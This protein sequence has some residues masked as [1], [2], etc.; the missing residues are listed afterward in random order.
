[1]A[2]KIDTSEITVVVQGAFVPETKECL[3]SIRHYLPNSKIV[4]ST[5]KGSDVSFCDAD[6]IVF[7]IDP[8]AFVCQINGKKRTNNI[9]RQILSTKNGLM[10]AKTKYAL[11][12]RTDFKLCGTE[13]LNY[14]C[15]FPAYPQDATWKIFKH[16][17]INF[18][19]LPEDCK[20]IPFF[21]T[22]FAFFGL[23]EDLMFLF[24]IPLKSEEWGMWFKTQT[25]A[26]PELYHYWQ[27]DLARFG[28][29]EYII[30]SA[31]SKIKKDIFSIVP[32]WSYSTREHFEKGHLFVLSNFITLDY[33]QFPLKSIA[34][35]YLSPL[36]SRKTFSAYLLKYK[37]FCNP[38]YKLPFKYILERYL[39][40]NQKSLKKI[41]K[42]FLYI[43][44]PFKATILWIIAVLGIVILSLRILTKLVFNLLI[45]LLKRE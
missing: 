24:D 29:E 10:R 9:N 38:K 6:E 22:D 11:K 26:N 5:W 20:Q 43:I 7:N 34:K 23:T 35:D 41:Q 19:D 4:L 37:K 31:L 39:H 44:A 12:M 13:F 25:P 33:R 36:N 18:C 40:K 32:D 15:A 45:L 21:V 8:G 1:M 28:P 17:V 14:F 16:K 27:G 3:E 42:N 30:F 2:K